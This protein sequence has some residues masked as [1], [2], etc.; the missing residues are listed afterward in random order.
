MASTPSIGL[1]RRSSNPSAEHQHF[2][3]VADPAV[4]ERLLLRLLLERKRKWR[5]LVSRA[6]GVAGD[7]A[8]TVAGCVENPGTARARL[9]AWRAGSSPAGDQLAPVSGPRKSEARSARVR[10][11]GDRSRQLGSECGQ[12]RHLALDPTEPRSSA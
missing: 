6:E 12:D 7:V 4:S 1:R 3:F 9:P 2:R 10:R 11:V 8:S 5:A